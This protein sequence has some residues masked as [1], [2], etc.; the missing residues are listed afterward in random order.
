MQEF[1]LITAG[2]VVTN[3]ALAALNVAPINGPKLLSK[4]LQAAAT[5]A[6]LFFPKAP[7][8]V[9]KLKQRVCACASLS[10]LQTTDRQVQTKDENL[11][12]YGSSLHSIAGLKISISI[13]VGANIFCLH[14]EAA[15]R[16]S[17]RR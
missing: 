4:Q 7:Q 9:S 5:F 14:V 6:R 15:N 1:C 12:M 11:L 3:L 2:S 13:L 8:K 17:G 10:R 16:R